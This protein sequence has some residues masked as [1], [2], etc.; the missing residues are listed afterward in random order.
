[1]EARGIKRG[2]HH[3]AIPLVG[4]NDYILNR[5]DD[6]WTET[7]QCKVKTCHVFIDL[8]SEANRQHI[9]SFHSIVSL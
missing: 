7:F 8:L 4:M 2:S 6:L 5:R 1:M 9:N 3:Q